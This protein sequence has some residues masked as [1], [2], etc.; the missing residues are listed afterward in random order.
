[1]EGRIV[2]KIPPAHGYDWD[3]SARLALEHPDSAVLAAEHVP[4]SRITSLREYSRP[5]FVSEDGTRLVAIRMRNSTLECD[6]GTGRKRR[7]GDVYFEA[8]ND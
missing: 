6:P 3:S 7:Y 1:M 5:P 8:V 2:S 4:V